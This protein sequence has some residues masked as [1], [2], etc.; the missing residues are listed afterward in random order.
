M[1]IIDVD[2]IQSKVRN[3]IFIGEKSSVIRS[4][5]RAIANNGRRTKMK[6]G[7]IG[8]QDER[9]QEKKTYSAVPNLSN[10]SRS[11]SFPGVTLPIK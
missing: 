6:N 4:N 5:N 10:M 8:I 11:A 3:H 9:F 1:T 2:S 7:Q